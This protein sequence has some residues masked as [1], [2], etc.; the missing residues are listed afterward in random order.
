[1]IVK[2]FQVACLHDPLKGIHRHLC[3]LRCTKNLEYSRY[4]IVTY[5]SLMTYNNNYAFALVVNLRN[6]QAN[7]FVMAYYT[8]HN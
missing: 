6:L 2:R 4:L 8:L 1:M 7:P 3:N 5:Q